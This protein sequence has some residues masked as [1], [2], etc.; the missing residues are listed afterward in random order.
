[1]PHSSIRKAIACNRGLTI[2]LL[3]LLGVH[4]VGLTAIMI[5]IALNRQDSDVFAL[6]ST[7]P[8]VS[9]LINVWVLLMV[10][11]GLYTSGLSCAV[12]AGL[13]RRAYLRGAVLLNLLYIGILLLFSIVGGG[14]CLALLSGTPASAEREN[15]RFILLVLWGLQLALHLLFTALGSLIGLLIL[16]LGIKVAAICM[17]IIPLTVLPFTQHIDA[18]MEQSSAEHTTVF[19]LVGVG[20]IVF[21][22]VLWLFC[23]SRFKKISL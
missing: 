16:R 21:S 10:S 11:S 9:I 4:L 22:V 5:V 19:T 20:M 17:G 18:F 2:T 14:I 12:H 15:F 23:S 3:I 7:F 6:Y 13:T 1:M 8:I